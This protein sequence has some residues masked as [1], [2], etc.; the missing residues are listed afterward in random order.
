MASV[1]KGT[2]EPKSRAALL[3]LWEE[4]AGVRA[5]IK[6]LERELPAAHEEV[7]LQTALVGHRLLRLEESRPLCALVRLVRAFAREGHKRLVSLAARASKLLVRYN[8]RLVYLLACKYVRPGV[9]AW[10]L[11]QEGTASLMHAVTKFEPERGYRFVTYAV[12]WIRQAVSRV[13]QTTQ[14]VVRF[15]C[16]QAEKMATIFRYMAKVE[17]ETGEEPTVKDIVKALE[18]SRG[19]VEQAMIWRHGVMSLD[20]RAFG[21]E[22][23]PTLLERLMAEETDLTAGAMQEQRSIMLER[24]LK[25]VLRGKPDKARLEKIIRMRYGFAPYERAHSLREV[26]KVVGI[27]SEAVRLKEREILSSMRSPSNQKVLRALL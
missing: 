14:E 10:D 23:K 8:L 24:I 3:A 18:L 5:L 4:V 6:R 11:F 16:H 27:T 26:A 9:S 19:V 15:P 20:A 22:D 1:E 13:A 2:K 7:G 25:K 12:Y 17:G 21:D